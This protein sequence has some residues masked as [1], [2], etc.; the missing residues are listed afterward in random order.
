MFMQYDAKLL[1]ER[2]VRK[3]KNAE[4]RALIGEKVRIISAYIRS[5]VV[6]RVG[7]WIE[8]LEEW[9]C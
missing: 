8:I 9:N 1:R 5:C 2:E 4:V 3:K 7:T 6:P